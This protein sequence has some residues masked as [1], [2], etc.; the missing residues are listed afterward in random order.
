MKKKIVGMLV[1]MLLIGGDGQ[2][3]IKNLSREVKKEVKK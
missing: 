2:D 1:M 3:R